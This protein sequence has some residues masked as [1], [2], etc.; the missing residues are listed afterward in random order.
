MG[1][2]AQ[3]KLDGLLN[4]W[5]TKDTASNLKRVFIKNGVAYLDWKDI[6]QLIPGASSSCGSASFL[7]P[8]E[9]TLKQ[10]PGVTKVIHAI[11]GKP[12]VFV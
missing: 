6:R 8:I 2:T 1:P 10:F 5:I 7:M 12:A 9:A 3:E 4:Y 11:E